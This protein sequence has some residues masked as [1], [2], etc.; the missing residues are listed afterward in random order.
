MGSRQEGAERGGKLLVGT[1]EP[2]QAL[3]GRGWLVP[4]LRHKPS[5]PTGPACQRPAQPH[6]LSRRPEAGHPYTPDG[7]K[8]VHRPLGREQLLI[9]RESSGL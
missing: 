8:P 1:A 4:V 9:G 5:C 7:E 2:H 3:G 6:S